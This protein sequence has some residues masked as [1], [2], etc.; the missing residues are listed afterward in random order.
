M[1]GMNGGRFKLLKRMGDGP[2]TGEKA[3]LGTHTDPAEAETQMVTVC[4][5][6]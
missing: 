2:D 3:P 5:A 1:Q 6:R 4:M